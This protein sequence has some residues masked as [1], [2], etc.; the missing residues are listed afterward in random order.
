MFWFYLPENNRISICWVHQHQFHYFLLHP[1][2]GSWR[3]RVFTD[4]GIPEE[5][6]SYL[7]NTMYHIDRGRGIYSFRPQYAAIRRSYATQCTRINHGYWNY[8]RRDGR[9]CHTVFC[10]ACGDMGRLGNIEWWTRN[11]EC[12][13]DA[14]PYFSIQNSLFGVRYSPSGRWLTIPSHGNL[15]KTGFHVTFAVPLFLA[16]LTKFLTLNFYLTWQ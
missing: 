4:G 16:G 5:W 8:Y 9:V 6:V 2:P 15:E 10:E 12:W 11:F 13:S 1:N 7:C 14:A 3:H